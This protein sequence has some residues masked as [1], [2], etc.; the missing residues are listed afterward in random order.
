M[1]NVPVPA[2]LKF[3]SNLILL[4]AIAGIVDGIAYFLHLRA[5]GIGIFMRVPWGVL[6]SYVSTFPGNLLT[7]LWLAPWAIAF[8]DLCVSRSR[9]AS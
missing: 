9:R 3:F 6:W 7:M 5:Q 8:V 2:G 4:G 1:K